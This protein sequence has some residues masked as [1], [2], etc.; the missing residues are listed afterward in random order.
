MRNEKDKEDENA[1]YSDAITSLKLTI[2]TDKSMSWDDVVKIGEA[3]GI[4]KLNLNKYIFG[5]FSRPSEQNY[6]KELIQSSSVPS[7]SNVTKFIET[8]NM[9]DLDSQVNKRILELEEKNQ[10]LPIE[11][12]IPLPSKTE[13]LRE[14]KANQKSS[15]Q[16]KNLDDVLKEANDFISSRSIKGLSFD[17]NSGLKDVQLLSQINSQTNAKYD[18]DKETRDRLIRYLQMIDN[19]KKQ[20]M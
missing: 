2:L 11:K 14:I 9:N 18:L 12:R 15:P 3:R 8:K 5:F 20:G 19:S 13:I 16:A 6:T 1:Q 4:S 17:K 7:P 10:N